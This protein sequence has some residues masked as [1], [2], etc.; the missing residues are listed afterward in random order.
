MHWIA[1]GLLNFASGNQLTINSTNWAQFSSIC[2]KHGK[3]LFSNSITCSEDGLKNKTE[4]SI[5]LTPTNPL[6]LL[7]H[8]VT[9]PRDYKSSTGHKG[10]TFSSNTQ[11]GSWVLQLAFWVLGS[12]RC[13][14]VRFICQLGLLLRIQ[15]WCNTLVTFPHKHFVS[16][17][18]YYNYLLPEFESDQLCELGNNLNN[19]QFGYP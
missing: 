13:L 16:Y 8:L 6:F 15:Q 3:K 19:S 9:I 12:A 10:L 17:E 1:A 18:C 4:T 5:W 7:F 14:K 11:I 2:S